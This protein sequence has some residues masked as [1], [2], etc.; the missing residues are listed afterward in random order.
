MDKVIIFALDRP[1]KK[2]SA[3][4]ADLAAIMVVFA[5]LFITNFAQ[6]R[7]ARIFGRSWKS[8]CVERKAIGKKYTRAR[9]K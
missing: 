7:L 3:A 2:G 6:P 1:P 9:T 8:S 5:G 4:W